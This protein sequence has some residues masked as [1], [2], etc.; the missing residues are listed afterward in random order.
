MCHINDTLLRNYHAPQ[1]PVCS[2]CPKICHMAVQ[3]AGRLSADAGRLSGLCER[4]WR[5]WM[6]SFPKLKALDMTNLREERLQVFLEQVTA[7]K[8]ELYAEDHMEPQKHRALEGMW[9]FQLDQ[10]SMFVCGGRYPGR[11]AWRKRWVSKSICWRDMEDPKD[12][13]RIRSISTRLQRVTME[14]RSDPPQT[15]MEVEYDLPSKTR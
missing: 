4:G 3:T 12:L 6:A 14:A 7:M 11:P 1:E 8:Q 15:N 10:L 2:A 13:W 5:T 9:I